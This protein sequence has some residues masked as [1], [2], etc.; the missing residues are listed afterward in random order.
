[1]FD[2]LESGEVHIHCLGHSQDTV[3]LEQQEENTH[4][5]GHYHIGR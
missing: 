4:T 2:V 5:G 3:V 1:M